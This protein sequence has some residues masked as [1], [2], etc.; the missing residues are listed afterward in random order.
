MI[1]V[2]PYNKVV[3]FGNF[4]KIEET[5]SGQVVDKHFTINTGTDEFPSCVPE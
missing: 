3:G 1:A 4:F 2:T 5:F